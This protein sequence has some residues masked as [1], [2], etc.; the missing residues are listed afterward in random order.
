MTPAPNH[1]TSV[2]RAPST[3]RASF[4]GDALMPE[5]LRYA[6]PHERPTLPRVANARDRR[7]G[8]DE[9]SACVYVFEA[10]GGPPIK[11]GISANP[12]A[13]AAD[14]QVGQARRITIFRTYRMK[15]IDAVALE[16]HIHR[17]LKKTINH[18]RGE[19]YD[20]DS[21]A[22]AKFIEGEISKFGL[23]SMCGA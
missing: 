1:P 20:L 19:W 2:L 4:P 5:K 7:F 9:P 12:A 6:K 10:D 13:R 22:A 23:Y 21:E 3:P 16:G 8:F 15:R 11:I 18:A 14:I 17:E